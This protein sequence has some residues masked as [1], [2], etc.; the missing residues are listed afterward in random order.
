MRRLAAL[1][2][3][4]LLLA[5]ALLPGC[6]AR[7][8]EAG[9][10]D[11][12]PPVY[13]EASGD[14]VLPDP[15]LPVPTALQFLTVYENERS[16]PYF[17]LEGLAGTAFADDGTLYV[18]DELGGRVHAWSPAEGIWYELDSPGNRF[19][20]PIDVHVDGFH[21]WVLDLDGRELLRYGATGAFLD[22]LVDFRY[23]D[24]GY[25]RIPTAFDV[26]VDGSVVVT[27]GG[28]DQALLLDSFLSLRQSVGGPGPHREQFKAPS[29]VVF[30]TDGGFVVS[31]RGN[32]RLQRFNRMGSYDGEVG[33][34]LAPGNPLLTPQGLERDAWD[35]LFV[36]DPAGGAVHVYDASLRH[37]FSA[38]SELGLLAAPESPIDV[39]VGPDDLLAVT[40]RSRAAIL[41]YRILYQ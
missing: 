32:R 27:D 30:L 31:D 7:T 29:G 28:E 21:V 16:A 11:L 26:D 40:D 38:G 33:G 20:R 18:C 14:E 15:D 39:A 13:D 17:P 19:F 41:I 6:S 4:G 35:N 34:E 37:V 12:P 8:P 9:Y 23:L 5:L 2:G 25:D 24:P 22:R 10:A 1:L 3:S 36:A